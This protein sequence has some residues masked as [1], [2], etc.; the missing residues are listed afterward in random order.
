MLFRSELWKSTIFTH[1]VG[2]DHKEDL[3]VS[4][5]Q[6]F[7]SRALIMDLRQDILCIVSLFDIIHYRNAFLFDERRACRV[8]QSQV[9]ADASAYELICA[10]GLFYVFVYWSLK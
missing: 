3:G 6:D 9:N 7:N 8:R 1:A 4:Q 10:G 5:S 2:E